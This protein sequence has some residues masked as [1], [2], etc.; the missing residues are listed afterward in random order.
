M[1][2][3]TEDNFAYID[4]ANLYNGITGFGRILNYARFRVSR[5]R[6]SPRWRQNSTRVF[7]VRIKYIIAN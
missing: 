7:F 3:K 5:K 4:G 6:K 1:D 2:L